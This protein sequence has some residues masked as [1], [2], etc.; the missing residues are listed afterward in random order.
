MRYLASLRPETE[1]ATR[2]A[3]DELAEKARMVDSPDLS[4]STPASRLP[5]GAPASYWFDLRDY[6]PVEVAAIVGKPMLILQGGRDYQVTVADD[7][8]RWEAGLG[9]RP[10]VTI[11]VYPE[12]N[13][14]FTPGS[15][16]STPAEYEP[17]QHVDATVIADIA[18]WLA[19]IPV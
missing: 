16:P 7:L 3:L 5:L 15:G 17:A 4:P 2:P 13:H 1:A 11:R 19:T 12:H 18:A 6:N 8:S 10:N 14:L 9:D